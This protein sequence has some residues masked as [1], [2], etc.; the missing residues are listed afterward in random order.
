[1]SAHFP[2][3]SFV[4]VN[5]KSPTRSIQKIMSAYFRNGTYAQYITHPARYATRL[6]KVRNLVC[7]LEE[8]DARVKEI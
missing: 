7:R 5:I 4:L 2:L 1:M 3:L 6:P 8:E